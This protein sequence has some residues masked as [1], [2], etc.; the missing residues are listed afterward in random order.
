MDGPK[1]VRF[2]GGNV[3]N[4]ASYPRDLLKQ[5]GWVGGGGGGAPIHVYAPARDERLFRKRP[6]VTDRYYD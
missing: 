4:V 5:W 1:E 6:I 3:L 2:F